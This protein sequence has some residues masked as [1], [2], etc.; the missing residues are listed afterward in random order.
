LHGLACC[1]HHQVYV[2]ARLAIHPNSAGKLRLAVLLGNTER[3]IPLLGVLLLNV[4]LLHAAIKHQLV[5]VNGCR[6]ELRVALG[7]LYQLLMTH[8]ASA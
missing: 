2:G 3:E 5:L 1:V 8:N 7:E 4:N 6:K